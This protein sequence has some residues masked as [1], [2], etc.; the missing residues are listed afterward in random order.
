MEE[1][2]SNPA[3]ASLVKL[4][5]QDAFMYSKHDFIEKSRERVKKVREKREER[6]SDKASSA[7]VVVVVPSEKT[8]P[9]KEK[10]KPEE[11]RMM[12]ITQKQQFG[13]LKIV[14]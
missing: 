5:L 9:R 2:I 1:G 14:L 10:R 11:N 12:D 3:P 4:S 7:H 6:Q 8:K 13:K